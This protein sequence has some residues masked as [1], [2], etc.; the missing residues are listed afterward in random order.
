MLILLGPAVGAECVKVRAA[1]VRG[2]RR[3]R[4]RE[5]RD[6]GLAHLLDGQVVGHDARQAQQHERRLSDSQRV[7]FGD[8]GRGHGAGRDSREEVLPRVQR[9][10]L[11]AH[12]L[13]EL[14]R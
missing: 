7:S 6:L 4:H 1:A 12:A 8:D 11:G 10:G 14:L 9:K 13:L 2:E 5:A 3:H